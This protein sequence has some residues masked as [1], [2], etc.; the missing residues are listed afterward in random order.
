MYFNQIKDE[1]DAN[2]A[3][4]D[5]VLKSLGAGGLVFKRAKKFSDVKN[6]N[7]T[8]YEPSIL[9]EMFFDSMFNLIIPKK[10]ETRRAA[11]VYQY[12]PVSPSPLLDIHLGRQSTKTEKIE[13]ISGVD[14]VAR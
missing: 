12:A 3:E 8:Y 13:K 11:S 1:F 4:V 10:Y 14:L 9:G 2:P 6:D 5:R 7:H